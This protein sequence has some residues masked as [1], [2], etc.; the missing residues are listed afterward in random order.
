M[1]KERFYI[2]NNFLAAAFAEKVGDT[3]AAQQLSGVTVAG[4]R[5]HVDGFGVVPRDPPRDVGSITHLLFQAGQ[6]LSQIYEVEIEK[7]DVGLS[8]GDSRN[9][10][11]RRVALAGQNFSRQLA[12]LYEFFRTVFEEG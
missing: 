9:G 6:P 12:G 1:T 5:C 4:L 7:K 3:G 11:L 2:F 8:L 10:L